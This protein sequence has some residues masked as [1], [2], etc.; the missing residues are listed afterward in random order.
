MSEREDGEIE[1]ARLVDLARLEVRIGGLTIVPNQGALELFDLG[2]PEG[3]ERARG[4]ELCENSSGPV[5]PSR[6]HGSAPG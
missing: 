3:V 2:R 6:E 1:L 4:A 5:A